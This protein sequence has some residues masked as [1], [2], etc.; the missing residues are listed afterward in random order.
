[1]NDEKRMLKA[2]GVD[3]DYVFIVFRV[4]KTRKGFASLV[5]VY[6]TYERATRA[7]TWL[8][9]RRKDPDEKYIIHKENV[10]S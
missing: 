7:I 8:T 2:V 9:E 1:M 5:G 3:D 10:K 4:T 6:K